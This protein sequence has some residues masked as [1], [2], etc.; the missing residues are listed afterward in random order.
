LRSELISFVVIFVS[1]KK[2]GFD[3]QVEFVLWTPSH[4]GR[5]YGRYSQGGKIWKTADF[6]VYLEAKKGQVARRVNLLPSHL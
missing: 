6:A 5:C 4:T 2:W 3:L 1:P